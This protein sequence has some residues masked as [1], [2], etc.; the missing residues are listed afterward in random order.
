MRTIATGIVVLALTSPAAAQEFA[1]AVSIYQPLGID[2][3]DGDLPAM[4]ELRLTVPF[5]GAI[6]IEPFV[7]AGMRRTRGPGTVEGFY[8]ARIRQRLWRPGGTGASLFA[9]Y[10]AAA[11][12]SR[13]GS[14]APVIG[15]F[16]V[17]LDQPLLGRVAFRPEVQLITFHVVPIGVRLTAGVST[18]FD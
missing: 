7:S 5:S 18:S 1:A 13:F 6:A 10:G 11:Y 4:L 17:G 16:G 12:Y 14:S 2:D 3:L 8:G 15:H 9:T